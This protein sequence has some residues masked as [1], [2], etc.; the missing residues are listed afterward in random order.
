MNERQL[1]S[2][3]KAAEYGSFSRAAADSYITTPAF[4]QQINLLEE[5]LGFRLFRRH[6][7]GVELTASGKVFYDAACQMLRLYDEA[8]DK[9]IALQ[10]ADKKSMKIGCPPE[11]F[12]DFVNQACEEFR[13]R[14]PNASIVFV[15]S[16]LN[17]NLQDLRTKKIDLCF[18]AEPDESCLDKLTFLPLY[19]ETFSFCMRKNHPFAVKKV[20]ETSDLFRYPILCGT[21]HYLRQP[22]NSFLPDGVTIHNLEAGYD[23]STQSRSMYSEDLIMIHSHWSNCYTST[24]KVIPSTIPAGRIGAV[25]RSPVSKMISEFISC[26]PR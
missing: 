10:N 11:Q 5:S 26:V 17:A 4:V 3:I 16:P 8:C 7:R 13:K 2:F 15:P 19:Q 23:A 18:M 24:L 21:Y 22:M 9:C 14:S 25:S 6:R 12:P 1:R 20:L